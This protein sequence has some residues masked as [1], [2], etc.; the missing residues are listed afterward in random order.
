[1]IRSAG[2]QRETHAN[3]RC[4]SPLSSFTVLTLNATFVGVGQSAEASRQRKPDSSKLG[5]SP[6]TKS[7]SGSLSALLH[8]PG[9]DLNQREG[10]E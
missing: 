3:A 5:S 9:L 8:R 2:Y 4:T 6:Y 10:S 1:M 7:F